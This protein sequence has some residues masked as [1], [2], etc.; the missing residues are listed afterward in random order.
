MERSNI[1][2][3]NSQDTTALQPNVFVT[4]VHRLLAIPSDIL[5]SNSQDTT[6]LQPNVFVTGVHR[7]LAIPSNG[8]PQFVLTRHNCTS[9]KCICNWNTSVTGHNMERS[10]IP[11]SNSQDTTELQPNCVCNWNTLV[12]GHNIERSDIPMHRHCQGESCS[13][14]S[15]TAVSYVSMDC[16]A[17]IFRV[18]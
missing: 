7:L 17:I 5:S 10:D 11:N 18:T 15:T 3:S 1:P 6:E 16:S 4:G 13:R 8:H 9:A 2:S 12:T 14:K